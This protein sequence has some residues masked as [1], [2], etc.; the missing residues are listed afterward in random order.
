MVAGGANRQAE[1]G[2]A[3][4][5]WTAF[6]EARARNSV[7]SIITHSLAVH[8]SANRGGI[9]VYDPRVINGFAVAAEAI[10]KHGTLL[11]GQ[12]SHG[13]TSHHNPILPTIV[14]PSAIACPHSGG[15]PHELS[16]TEI[17]ELIDYHVL[18]AKN[19]QAAGFDGVEVHAA[20][21]HLVQEFL[22]PVSNQRNDEYGGSFE[23]RLTF[24][25][26]ILGAIREACDR[27]FIVGLRLGVEEFTPGGIGI[28][29][30]M[31]ITTVLAAQQMVDF[32]D[33]TQSNFNSL[34]MHTP[35]RWLPIAPYVQ[36][37]AAVKGCARDIP[38]VTSG[39][40]PDPQLAEEILEK[41]NADFIG[42]YRPLLADHEW[43]SKAFQGNSDR[44][45]KC[46]YCNQCWG[47]SPDGS[48][49]C[50]QNAVAGKERDW[51]ELPRMVPGAPVKKVVVIGGGPAGMEAARVLSEYG[52]RVVLFERG[53]ALGG[54][55][56]LAGRLEDEV[57]W[58][59]EYLQGELHH[60]GVDVRLGT[61]ATADT[62]LAEQA[63]AVVI[64][65]GC[66]DSRDSDFG[67]VDLPIYVA[68][69]IAEG[70]I[71]GSATVILDDDG[72]YAGPA[73][74][75]R[76][77]LSG[78]TVYLVTRFPEVA[79]EVPRTSRISSIRELDNLGVELIPN[80]WVRS[81]KHGRVTLENYLSKRTWTMEGIDSIVR[82]GHRIAQDS[83]F[84]SL[85][86]RTPIV[87]LIGD[88]YQPRRIVNAV[89]EGH[90]VA[91][92]L[93]AEMA[94]EETLISPDFAV[95]NWPIRVRVAATK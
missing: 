82:V 31:E 84:H 65:T 36:F 38:V 34:E 72:Y 78:K 54:T 76:L 4:P 95:G 91:R 50:I 13:G 94:Q 68:E 39:R 17:R 66:I 28:E 25:L 1:N 37:A 5:K 74:A 73:V 29:D 14:G 30:A 16:V 59:A 23:R 8:P 87:R 26:E 62:V 85:R 3:G 60:L 90:A 79:R 57:Q 69:D 20:N 41:K 71:G 92:E 75:R 86:G 12:L 40:I 67:E 58:V 19:L 18:S 48:L 42:F 81:A 7:G 89:M 63:D 24:L 44:I 22:S 45:R 83:L 15:V 70:E 55:V 49:H 43:A 53:S 35:D 21:G 6:Y 61:E 52:S 47:G 46:I 33:V 32:L 80:A 9:Q 2:L 51:L 93:A 77:A 10:H 64:A 27:S 56:R 88:A 11:L